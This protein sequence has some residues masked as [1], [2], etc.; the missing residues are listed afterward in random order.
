MQYVLLR[1]SAGLACPLVRRGPSR[2]SSLRRAEAPGGQRCRPDLAA[3]G[4]QEPVTCLLQHVFF[5]IP[6]EAGVRRGR[7][8]ETVPC[9]CPKAGDFSGVA[10]LIRVP[11]PTSDHVRTRGR[12]AR[13]VA[14]RR[15]MSALLRRLGSKSSRTISAHFSPRCCAGKLSSERR[16]NTGSTVRTSP[17]K[18]PAQGRARAPAFLRGVP[19]WRPPLA[20]AW[21]RCAIS[22]TGTLP[23]GGVLRPPDPCL[24][25]R[26]L[27]ARVL[28]SPPV[29]IAR[30]PPRALSP[31]RALLRGGRLFNARAGREGRG[32]A[33]GRGAG[34]Q[35][36]TIQG[37]WSGQASSPA[38]LTER[39]APDGRRG[40]AGSVRSGWAVVREFQRP[41]GMPLALRRRHAPGAGGWAWLS[42]VASAHLGSPP[43]RAR[44]TK[45][46]AGARTG[47]GE[48]S[49]AIAS[50]GSPR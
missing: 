40:Q 26:G 38:F 23:F 24:S 49:A 17:R 31:W 25:L 29:A 47:R 27:R 19:R 7:G 46:A 41:S 5:E 28:A 3:H 16:G 4:G 8:E 18:L 11:P 39:A 20:T 48:G 34:S 45:E 22:R 9:S 12:S 36:Q 35:D 42:A 6:R 10:V 14:A 2:R 37:S 33:P 30:E 15:P 1:C 21:G 32:A 44:W 43:T 13:P 50:A